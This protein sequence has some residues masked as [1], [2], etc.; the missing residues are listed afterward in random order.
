M[1]PPV[2]ALSLCVTLSACA[3]AP[4]P[5]AVDLQPARQ[6]LEAARAEGA[7]EKAPQS[8]TRAQ[9]ELREAENLV[10]ARGD[11]TQ[12]AV[13]AEWAA[14]LALTE[15]RCVVPEPSPSAP[16]DDARR[17]ETRAR[18]A[19]EEKRRLEEE[20]AARRRE[21]EVTETELIR[22]KARLKG[23]ETRAEAASAIAEARIL[24]RRAE[25]RGRS[26]EVARAQESLAKAE[27]LLKQDNFGAAIFF[28]SKAQ[29]LVVKVNEPR[30]AAAPAAAD[31]EGPPPRPTCVVKAATANLRESPSTSAPVLAAV[32]QGTTLEALAVRA[33]WTK[34]K[35]G[36]VVGWILSRLVESR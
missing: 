3:S 31:Q 18:R 33:G 14:R 4:K 15:A 24:L 2:L 22:T 20:N 13:K 26:A 8:F 7:P 23:L 9:D 29:D 16:P 12:A 36:D 10:A 21:L 34:V 35:Q 30:A 1:R 6:A 19:E 27:E 5:R 11:A 32:A 28:A 17:L 25:G